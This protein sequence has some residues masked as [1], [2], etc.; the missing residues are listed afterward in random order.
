LRDDGD[1]TDCPNQEA[2]EGKLQD[3]EDELDTL[4]QRIAPILNDIYNLKLRRMGHT[5]NSPESEVVER[6]IDNA[7]PLIHESQENLGE[8]VWKTEA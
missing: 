5:F 4:K 1:R 3:T 8:I 2:L 6:L 7:A